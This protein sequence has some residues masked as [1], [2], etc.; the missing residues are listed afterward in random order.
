MARTLKIE[1]NK[2]LRR[3]LRLITSCIIFIFLTGDFHPI[4]T[5][6][7]IAKPISRRAGTVPTLLS[8]GT[9]EVNRKMEI[10]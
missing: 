10:L 6:A 5:E 4:I 8:S 7:D 1:Q 9:F 2:Y 3:F